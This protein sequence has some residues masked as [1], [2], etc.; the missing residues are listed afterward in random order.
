[1]AVLRYLAMGKHAFL[2]FATT[3]HGE[4]K[5]LKYSADESAQLFENACVEFDDVAMRPTF[6]LVWGIPGRS[7]A[8]AIA[9]RLGL[10]PQ[11]VAEARSLLTS[12]QGTDGER[13]R[14]DIE[15]MIRS[16]ESDK[17]TAE[18]ARLDAER[19]LS[20]VVSMRDEL[21]SRLNAL[22]KREAELRREQRMA[23][24]AE[25]NAARKEIA[26]VIRNLQQNGSAQG[27][28]RAS[29][30]LK[31]I[32]TRRIPDSVQT[33]RNKVTADDI[34]IGDCVVVY[35]M[36]NDEAEVVDKISGKEIVVAMGP[37]K[38]KV[39]LSNVISVRHPSPS[40]TKTN[41]LPSP[42]SVSN[43][44][45]NGGSKKLAMRTAANSIDVRGLRVEAATTKIDSAI[46]KALPMGALWIIHGHG[47]GRL[48]SGVRGFLTEHPLVNKVADAD[49]S[50]GG[51]GVSIAYF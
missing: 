39:K 6:R 5:T 14:V 31:A 16:L 38:V 7:N 18:E 25:V 30:Q 12:G 23:M 36:G 29:D 42:V 2:T 26:R 51:S 35:G 47:T 37:M 4:L 3:H 45:S 22:R 48:R 28:S 11:V 40:R 34:E 1:M 13:A 20:E 43:S 50:E 27:A 41:I 21:D 15:K 33:K 8:L 10:N 49:Q 17:K 19:K 32:E 46:D 44:P 9:E 24:D